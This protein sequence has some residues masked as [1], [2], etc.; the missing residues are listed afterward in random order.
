MVAVKFTGLLEVWV[1]NSCLRCPLEDKLVLRRKMGG[2]AYV[3][4]QAPSYPDQHRIK[5]SGCCAT[6]PHKSLEMPGSLPR[7]RRGRQFPTTATQQCYLLRAF[8]QIGERPTSGEGRASLWFLLSFHDPC[9]FKGLQ[10]PP[11]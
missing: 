1:L 5:L 11:C 6:L 10:I 2:K 8:I 3:S 4:Q 7:V 9:S